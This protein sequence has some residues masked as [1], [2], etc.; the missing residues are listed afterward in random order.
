MVDGRILQSLRGACHV[1]H[2]SRR[3]WVS[4]VVMTVVLVITA[5][6]VGSYCG[7]D[8]GRCSCGD[9]L[10][11]GYEC[12]PVAIWKDFGWDNGCEEYL[13]S[14]FMRNPVNALSNIGFVVVGLW[15]SGIALEDFRFGK[16]RKPGENLIVANPILSLMF[17]FCFTWCG[18]GSFLFHASSTRLGHHLDMVSVDTLILFPIPYLVVRMFKM[19]QTYFVVC[20]VFGMIA[21]AGVPFM[22]MWEINWGNSFVIVPVV[23]SADFFLSLVSIPMPD[24][25][26]HSLF[27]WGS[28]LLGML[29]SF[30]FRSIDTVSWA[31]KPTSVYQ[32]HAAWHVGASLSIFLFYLFLRAELNDKKKGGGEGWAE[33]PSPGEEGYDECTQIELV[34]L[35]QAI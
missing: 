28:A 7:R 4:L 22:R 33:R 5:L 16:I 9:E 18:V 32:G 11:E 17:S 6:S 30:G 19:P 12:W 34:A 35:G 31:C 27:L 8:T 3:M 25:T 14:D 15:V 24:R 1:D 13:Q 20:T 26:P 10:E 2:V 23:G 21:A 29:I